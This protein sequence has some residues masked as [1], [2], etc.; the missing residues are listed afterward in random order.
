MRFASLIEKIGIILISPIILLFL[1]FL[2]VPGWIFFSGMDWWF[3]KTGN[4]R[5]MKEFT[6]AQKE[7][8]ARFKRVEARR[9]NSPNAKEVLAPMTEDWNN[10]NKSLKEKLI[11]LNEKCKTIL[12]KTG[13]KL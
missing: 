10:E 3:E 4:G 8:I 13:G 9:Y 7:L 5:I 12:A 6:E 2:W 1:L 11:D